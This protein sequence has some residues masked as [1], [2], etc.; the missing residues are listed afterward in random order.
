MTLSEWKS[1][2]TSYSYKG[3]DIFTIDE[4]YGEVV[5]AIHGFPTASWDWEQMWGPLTTHY[6]VLTLDMIGFGFSDKPKK[7]PYS[8]FDQADLFEVFLESKKV[9]KVKIISHDY[10]D[11]V[12]QELLARFQ[13]RKDSEQKGTEIESICLLNGGLFPETHH[14][15]LIQKLLMSPIGQIVGKLMSR[16]KLGKNFQKIFGPNTQP[17]E[18]ELDDFWKLIT[19][20]EGKDVF[21]LLIRYMQE[22]SENRKRWVGALQHASIP[23][24]LINGVVDPISGQHMADRYKEIIPSPDVIELA[25]IGHFPLVEAPKTVMKH[26]MDF[27]NS[28]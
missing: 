20:N 7:Y 25:K 17:S 9:E 3:H 6:R 2:G 24:R 26:Y 18:S 13:E 21:H 12:A 22:R 10:G 5:L 23:L 19:Y 27:L 11:T 1:K 15:L 16:K 28:N 8:I 4:G 14:P